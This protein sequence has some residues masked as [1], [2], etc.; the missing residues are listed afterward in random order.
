MAEVDRSKPWV[1]ILA[2]GSG[3]RFWPA[4][5]RDT[6]KH[7]LPLG[8]G[9]ISLLR[10][11]VGRA[12][13]VTDAGRVVVVTAADQ[14]VAVRDDVGELLADDNVIAEPVPRNTAPAIALAMVHLALRGAGPHEPVIVVPS[15]HG[16]ADVDAWGAALRRAVDA[17]CEHKA[18]VTLGI[19]PSFPSTGFGYVGLGGEEET[20]GDS[21]L[22]V[23]KVLQFKEKPTAAVAREY[24][25]SGNWWWNGG[26]F[27]FRLGYLWYVMGDLREDL[28]LAMQVLSACIQQDDPVAML[29]E[30]GK[31]ESI[32]IDYAVMEQAPSMLSVPLDCGWSDLGSWDAMGDLAVAEDVVAVESSNNVVYAPGRT[33]ALV[34]ASD[35]V[36]VATDD[37]VLV[38]P[39]ERAQEVRE[40]AA[41]LEARGRDDLL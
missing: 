2:G 6:P 40:I 15:D 16:V 4:S 10:A 22:P 35:L 29:E 9:G 38:A 28:D 19:R 23:R 18:I 5:R 17:A 33:V 3:R 8:D 30:Y 26:M 34:G 21:D 37:A 36:V 14:E 7:L 27:V 32:S 41:A 20:E 11:T 25:A 13:T 1:L 31:L 24:V 39:R 12:R